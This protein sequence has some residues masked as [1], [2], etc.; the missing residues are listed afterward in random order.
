MGL[1]LGPVDVTV[2]AGRPRRTVVAQVTR[3]TLL[4]ADACPA[5]GQ[6]WR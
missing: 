1:E 3:E 2:T 5:D 4:L 6:A